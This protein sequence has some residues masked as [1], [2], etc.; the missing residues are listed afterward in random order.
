[1]AKKH[2]QKLLKM[3]D[4]NS[5]PYNPFKIAKALEIE[6]DNVLTFEKIGHSGSISV[7]NDKAV[8]WV[9]WWDIEERQRFTVAHEIGHYILHILPFEE[10]KGFIDTP[11]TIYGL[12]NKE[13]NKKVLTGANTIQELEATIFASDLLMPKKDILAEAEKMIDASE[14]KP[15]K[16]GKFIAEMARIFVVS[17]QQMLN[18]LK[19]CDLVDNNYKL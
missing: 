9:N 13:K 18:K 5:P 1:M 12:L 10:N 14:G 16:A 7:K 8:I 15:I 17:K 4:F 6:I 19:A 3:F 2:P 11:E